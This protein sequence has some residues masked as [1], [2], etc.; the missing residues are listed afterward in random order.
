M[1]AF[2]VS[3]NVEDVE[4]LSKMK[5]LVKEITRLMNVEINFSDLVCQNV[6]EWTVVNQY[7]LSK[8]NFQLEKLEKLKK[9]CKF[10]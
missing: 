9:L 1:S 4:M 10:A 3:S 5:N 2:K 8:N 6:E 7:R